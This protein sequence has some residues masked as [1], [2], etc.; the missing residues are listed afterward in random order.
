V[1]LD[2]RFK[3]LDFSKTTL[4]RKRDLP[5]IGCHSGLD[6]ESIQFWI[7]AFAGM[8]NYDSG[9]ARMTIIF[10]HIF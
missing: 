8:T 5:G 4:R 9:R 10:Y 1:F 6:P 2:L 7:P 3:T